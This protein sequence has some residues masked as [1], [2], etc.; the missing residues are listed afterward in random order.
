[1][2]LK[3]RARPPWV[4]DIESTPHRG[5]LKPSPL[6]PDLYLTKYRD[7]IIEA[8]GSGFPSDFDLVG[9]TFNP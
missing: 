3:K 6:G 8:R 4:L 5:E 1:M 2:I 9:L 7:G